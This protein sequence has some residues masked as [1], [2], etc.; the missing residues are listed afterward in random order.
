M[1]IATATHPLI[2][3]ETET[4]TWMQY[5]RSGS[6]QPTIASAYGAGRGWV[7][8]LPFLAAMAAAIVLGACATE[9]MRLT[10]RALAAGIAAAATWALLAAIMPTTLGL[11]SA[12]LHKIV[13]AGDP[14]ALHKP[15]GPYPLTDLVLV[16]LGAG[17]L[18][19][20][21][22][23]LLRHRRR[24]ALPRERGGRVPERSPETIAATVRA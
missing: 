21:L 17:L 9:R 7:A 1:A 10:P 4:S 15:W 5:L 24:P 8:L 12:A 20:M 14:T 11:D 2:G 18:S 22:A 16:A 6:F 3:Y 19:L 13:A 23:R